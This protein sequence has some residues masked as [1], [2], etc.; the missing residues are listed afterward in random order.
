MKSLELEEIAERDHLKEWEKHIE[1]MIY[2]PSLTVFAITRKLEDQVRFSYSTTKAAM[3]TNN[4]MNLVT[5]LVRLRRRYPDK[6]AKIQRLIEHFATE[7]DEM[8]VLKP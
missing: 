6:A 7:K 2:A 8:V 4:R 1:K 5:I 3:T